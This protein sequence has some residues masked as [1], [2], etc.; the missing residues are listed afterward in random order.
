MQRTLHISARRASAGLS[1][2]LSQDDR[3]FVEMKSTQLFTRMLRG[4]V[5]NV[6]FQDL[7]R[8]L[9]DLGF[10]ERRGRGSH[11]I[12]TRSDIAE[13]VNLQRERGDAKAYQVRQVCALIR[14]Y[15]LRLEEDS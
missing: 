5:A 10:R 15:D 11:H 13:I 6:D 2:R 7:I 8:L 9:G 1:S 3:T 4:E 14:K 12:F